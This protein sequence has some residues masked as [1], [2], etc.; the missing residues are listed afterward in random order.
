MN[1]ARQDP[2]INNDDNLRRAL[3]EM[4]MQSVPEAGWEERVIDA[5]ERHCRHRRVFVRLSAFG[6]T[7]VAAA[8]AAVVFLPR[9]PAARPLPVPLPAVVE[10]T[11][12]PVV[13]SVIGLPAERPQPAV[14]VAPA[15]AVAPARTP[16]V[17]IPEPAVYEANE[18]SDIDIPIGEYIDDL[19]AMELI[20]NHELL[21][22]IT[23]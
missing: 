16:R 21:S 20:R 23:D 12:P 13:A 4:L 7:A 2:E 3:A 1:N 15:P 14:H 10:A 11:A 5:A 17:I 8:I 19:I 9:N 18:P 6:A 22:S